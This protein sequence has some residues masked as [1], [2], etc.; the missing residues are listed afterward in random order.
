MDKI[1]I[2]L[3]K[4][5]KIW[6][7][8]DTHIGHKNV[9]KFSNRPYENIKEM[10]NDFVN[11]WNSVV[12]D[13]DYVF[14]L[15]DVVWNHSRNET[16]KA[17]KELKGIKFIIPGNHD[18]IEQFEYCLKN[19]DNFH[20][21]SDFTVLYIRKFYEDSPDK[22]LELFLSHCPMMTW[23]HRNN[24]AINLFGHIHSGPKTK[25]DV[26][27]DLPLFSYQYDCGVDNNNYTPIEIRDILQKLNF[28]N[29]DPMKLRKF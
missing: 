5:Q 7:T 25:A 3:E 18:K 17:L 21:L 14:H 22:P 29:E 27:Q 9:I 1:N 11:K 20:V 19:L 10:F 26:D 4:D 28:P 2:Y 24:N 23:P 6:F 12:S 8:S 15:G 13:N 16:Y